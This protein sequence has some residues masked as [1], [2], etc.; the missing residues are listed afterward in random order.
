MGTAERVL[1]VPDEN[2]EQEFYAA[3]DR[4][5]KDVEEGR[6]LTVEE[7]F[8]NVHKKIDDIFDGKA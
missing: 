4:G 3:I 1:I 8:S 2:A 6:L 5:L 7:V